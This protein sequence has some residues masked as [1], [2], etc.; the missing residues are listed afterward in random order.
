[1]SDLEAENKL[2]RRILFLR[3]GCPFSALY[4]DDGEMQCHECGLDFKRDSAQRIDEKFTEMGKE[5][6]KKAL[7]GKWG[8]SHE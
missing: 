7:G 5:R 1:M 8:G 3:H 4:Y 6:F 2:L